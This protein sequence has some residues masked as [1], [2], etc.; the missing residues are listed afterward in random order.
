MR[1]HVSTSRQSERFDA[2]N[3]AGG[4]R[5]LNTSYCTMNFCINKNPPVHLVVF[6]LTGKTLFHR[7]HE[8]VRSLT[9]PIANLIAIS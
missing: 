7:Q 9:M 4:I 3:P 6:H 1:P 5:P 8:I 2:G